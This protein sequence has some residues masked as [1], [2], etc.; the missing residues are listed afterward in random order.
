MFE[1]TS[2]VSA[3]DLAGQGQ[4]FVVVGR[5]D[6]LSLAFLEVFLIPG[7]YLGD[8]L[9]FRRLVLGRGLGRRGFLFGLL[10]WRRRGRRQRLFLGFYVEVYVG[11]GL[12]GLFGLG[13]D[14][15]RRCWGEE[16]AWD[17]LGV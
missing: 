11:F 14:W 15:V 12:L 8:L 4:S 3:G 5:K 1:E 7:L 16:G 17:V 6:L 13:L 9:L 10:N 2:D